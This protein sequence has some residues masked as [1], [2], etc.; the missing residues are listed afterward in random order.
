MSAATAAVL[1]EEMRAVE[2]DQAVHELRA[3]TVG[4][5]GLDHRAESDIW[6]TFMRSLQPLLQLAD[7]AVA[8]RVELDAIDRRLDLHVQTH[9][10]CRAGLTCRSYHVL[11]ARRQRLQ[12]AWDRAYIRL[13]KGG[14]R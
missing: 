14:S 4:A 1:P 5:S 7:D 12:A 2:R 10:T 13:A 6:R 3:W 9:P 11:Q 8:A